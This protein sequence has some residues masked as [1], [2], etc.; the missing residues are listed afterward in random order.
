MGYTMHA[1][2][3]VNTSK[4]HDPGSGKSV[5]EFTPAELEGA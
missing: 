1:D 4:S 5:L 3:I 2:A